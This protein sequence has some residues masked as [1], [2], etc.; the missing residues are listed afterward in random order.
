MAYFTAAMRHAGGVAIATRAVMAKRARKVAELVNIV[1]VFGKV[2]I[3]FR[4]SVDRGGSESKQ[5][6]SCY[7][8]YWKRKAS[9]E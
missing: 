9:K 1:A 2:S 8:D 6:T 4:Y 5:G 7:H 3:G